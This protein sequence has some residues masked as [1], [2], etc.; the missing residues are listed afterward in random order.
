[1][2]STISGHL[3][4]SRSQQHPHHHCLQKSIHT[5]QYLHLDSNH[6]IRAN[7]VFSTLLGLK[8]FPL[9]N[10]HFTKEMDTLG[11]PY[12]SAVSRH[13]LSTFYIT[14]STAKTTSTMNKLPLTTNPTT[15]KS[16]TNNKKKNITI[17]VTYIHGWWERFKRT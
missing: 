9:I 17:V 13:G 3:G 15:T 11:K 16:G 7:I 1:M 5:D 6:F 14:N 12:R 8:Q 2:S 10:E 4:V